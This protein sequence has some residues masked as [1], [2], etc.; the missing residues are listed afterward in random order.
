MHPLTPIDHALALVLAVFFPI[1]SA[2][3]GYRRLAVAA[4][5]E[6]P[7]VRGQLYT[8]ALVIQWGLA[9]VVAW[10]WVTHTRPASALAL[11]WRPGVGA[12]VVLGALAALT[13]LIAL[14]LPRALADPETLARVRGRLG[15]IRRMLPERRDEVARFYLLSFTAGVCEE[16]LYRGFLFDYLRHL[17]PWPAAA[18]GSV[19][20]FGLGHSYQGPRGMLATALAGTVLM[21]MVL[22]SGSLVP[23]MLAHMLLDAYSGTLGRH[24]FAAGHDALAAATPAPPSPPA[25]PAAG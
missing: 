20:L 15:H 6:V 4:D 21:G 18:A 13:G 23:A 7:R 25:R 17:V 12:W 5:S 9:A 22:V 8:Q 10:L 3:F 11:V 16:L 14:Q 2:T 24:A 19:I 1:R